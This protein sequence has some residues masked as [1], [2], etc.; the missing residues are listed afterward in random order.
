M[1]GTHPIQIVLELLIAALAKVVLVCVLVFVAICFV[2]VGLLFGGVIL[3]LLKKKRHLFWI[4]PLINFLIYLLVFPVVSY[5]LWRDEMTFSDHFRYPMV[6]LT[7]MAFLFFTLL[8]L[9]VIGNPLW[10]LP[11]AAHPRSH[12]GDM[13]AVAGDP[14]RPLLREAG[15]AG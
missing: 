4:L 2:V 8:G 7:I 1:H 3:A 5:W 15:T 11:L 13:D 12:A 14:L 9:V 10:R 6:D